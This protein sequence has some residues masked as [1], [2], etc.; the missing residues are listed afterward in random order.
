MVVFD[1][2]PEAAPTAADA[3]L[4]ESMSISGLQSGD[5]DWTMWRGDDSWMDKTGDRVALQLSK[6]VGDSTY[7]EYEKRTRMELLLMLDGNIQRPHFML[8][9][10]LEDNDFLDGAIYKYIIQPTD[11]MNFLDTL[12]QLRYDPPGPDTQD[13][14]TPGIRGTPVSNG[15]VSLPVGGHTYEFAATDDFF[16]PRG[17]PHV[18]IGWPGNQTRVEYWHPYPPSPSSPTWHTSW[19]REPAYTRV[20]RPFGYPYDSQSGRYPDVNPVLSA[21]PYFNAAVTVSPYLPTEMGVAR[22]DEVGGDPRQVPQIRYE[23]FNN[24]LKTYEYFPVISPFESVGPQ[25]GPQ[26]SIVGASPTRPNQPTHYTNDDTIRPNYANIWEEAPPD[27][28]AEP[29]RGGRWTQSTTYTFL[30]NYWRKPSRSPEYIRCMIRKNDR[31]GAPTTWR[32]FT[33]QQLNPNDTDY[34]DGAVFQ[35]QISAHQLPSGGGPGDYNYYFIASDGVRTTIFP[36]RPPRFTE[37]ETGQWFDDWDPVLPQ[38]NPQA[39]LGVPVDSTG[40]NDYYWFRVNHPPVLTSN[41]VQPRSSRTGANFIY[42]VTY[43]DV[44]GEVLVPNPRGDE[45]F[46]ATITID[47]FGDPE[48]ENH[49]ASVSAGALTYTTQTGR[50]YTANSL[51]NGA[52]PYYVRI[53]EAA[54]PAAVGLTYQ[55]TGNDTSRIQAT[56]VGSAPPLGADPNLIKAGDRFEILQ[57]FTGT[58]D[59]VTPSDNTAIDGIQYMFNTANN[60]SLGPGLHRYYFQFIDD[61]GDWAY[62]DRADVSVRGE[63]TRFP[64]TSEFEGP[65]VL[66]NTAPIL[67]NYRFTPDAP[68]TGPDGTTATGFQ[69]YVTYTDAENDPPNVIRLG[70]DGTQDSPA[71]VLNM[72]ASDPND[73][74]YTDG[75]VFETPPIRLKAGTHVFRAQAGDGELT[76]PVKASPSDP[77][78]F[79][80]ELITQGPPPQYN[81]SKPGPKVAQNTPPTLEFEPTDAIRPSPGLDPDAGTQQTTFTYHIIYKDLD[82]FAGVQGNPPIWVQVY[83]DGVAQDMTQVDASDTDY[84]DGALF[85]YQVSGLV[86]GTAHSYYFRANDGLDVARQPAL[87]DPLGTKY[88]GPKV[89][90]PPGPPKTLTVS[91]FPN[92]QGGV[93]QGSFNPSNDDGGGAN[94]VTEYRVYYDT[95]AGMTNPKLAATVQATGAGSYSFVHNKAPK[96]VDL[97]Y[98]VRAYDGTNESVDS[99]VAGPIRATD[100]LAPGAPSNLTATNPGAGTR[101]DLAWTKSPDDGAGAKDVTEYRVYRAQTSGGYTT[102]LATVPAG[103]ITYQDTTASDG[104]DFYYVVRAFDGT[105]ESVNS[106]E[107]GPVQST[108]NAPPVLSDFD[109]APGARNVPVDTTIAFTAT[110]TGAGVD[111]A[112]LKLAVTV[113]GAAV[114]GDLGSPVPVPDGFRWTFTPKSDFAELSPVQVKIDISDLARPNPRKATKTYRFTIVA[115]PT[116]AVSGTITQSDGAGGVKPVEGVTVAAGR[117]SGL[118]D[119]NGQYTIVG[120]TNGSYE[121]VPSK[122]GKAFIPASRTITVASAD[123][124]GVDFTAVKGYDIVGTVTDAKGPVANVR[125][126]N[127]LQEVLTGADGVYKLLDSPA[128]VYVVRPALPGSVFKPAQREVKLPTAGGGSARKVDFSA[129]PETFTIS[130]QISTADGGVLAGATVTAETGGTGAIA[131]TA[132]TNNSGGYQLKGVLAGTYRIKAAK[133]GFT[134]EPVSHDVTVG[135]SAINQDFVALELFTQSF[136]AGLSF[137]AVPAE[138]ASDDIVAALGTDAVARWDPRS[139]K[140]DKYVYAALDPT[141]SVL[142][143]APGR[144][145]FARFDQA[146]T[147][148]IAGKL[149]RVSDAFNLSLQEGFNMAGNPYP[150]ALPWANLA[151]SGA[152]PVADFGFVLKPG[153]RQYE[154]VSDLPELHGRLSIPRGAGF[155]IQADRATVLLINGPQVGA[156]DSPVAAEPKVDDRN[157]VVPITATA[158]VAADLS[159][160]AGI[161]ETTGAGL[162]AANPPAAAGMVD[163]YFIAADGRRLALDIRPAGGQP[164]REWSFAVCTDLRNTPITVGLPDLSAVPK[165][166]RVTLVDVAA[167]K[168]IFARLMPQYTYDSRQGGERR[169]RLIVEPERGGNLAITAASAQANAKSVQLSYT[170]SKAATVTASV[171]NLA[172]REVATVLRG[173][174]AAA[175]TNVVVWN[176]KNAQGALVPSGTYLVVL[177]AVADDGEQARAMRSVT[178]HR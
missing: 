147:L 12:F 59:R 136:P 20:V 102:A 81:D 114:P 51:V 8:R 26:G 63:A 40:A 18:Q 176:L 65:E 34:S 164:T 169:F 157:W 13:I 24:A 76:Y 118:S 141:S 128:G 96:G 39:D 161:M 66:Q 133:T 173:Q 32:G 144:G 55:I 74:V 168:S 162:Q 104:T 5:Y 48:G 142:D 175:G 35:F 86:A 50:G 129:S 148:Q 88:T 57:W 95:V 131:A 127:G 43:Q 178:I 120:L 30:I 47:L 137:L 58:M 170:L 75:A 151:I 92:D 78:L 99:N 116:Y 150:V 152:G 16:P 62:P 10:N 7:P 37:M 2:L 90:Q 166:L 103:T 53:E 115:P 3:N 31:G 69:F 71:T 134:F 23:Q 100:N 45:P 87:T 94:D 77:L 46:Q 98:V 154:L 143:L 97:W 101:I 111:V 110:D 70:I 156:A 17:I 138:P 139:T 123:V 9:E 14:L 67:S 82:V 52:R 145:Y 33:M 105:N 107:A 158:P 15:Y 106:N 79:V 93:T 42:Y 4:T 149:I 135:P 38:T 6:G 108:D 177:E 121:I 54:N 68:G 49:V 28:T 21:F 153:T 125:V 1:R 109:P 19:E 72:V 112:S 44:D 167:N 126:T 122:S 80:G 56:P 132:Q 146:R 85:E 172:G 91:D 163:L 130:G 117:L 41:D 89:D 160:R 159:S 140:A 113:S 11:F 22:W 25:G 124:P 27:P 83:V 60:I 73:T 61:W 174:P 84:T 36:N 64:Q 29:F 119:R 171:R 165:D 155:W